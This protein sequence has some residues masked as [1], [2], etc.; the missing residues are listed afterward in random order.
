[1]LAELWRAKTT[2]GMSNCYSHNS[3]LIEPIA[4]VPVLLPL[5][6]QLQPLQ[7]LL[8]A[9]NLPNRPRLPHLPKHA[10][11]LLPLPQ[12]HL[13]FQLVCSQRLRSPAT[14]ADPSIRPLPT[15]QLRQGQQRVFPSSIAPVR[16]IQ[17]IHRQLVQYLRKSVIQI[18]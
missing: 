9:Q 8:K 17:Y 10:P 5:P 16:I 4:A 2:I 1:M 12:P 13:L 6:Y 15:R 18:Y 11:P 3:C 14:I 7:M